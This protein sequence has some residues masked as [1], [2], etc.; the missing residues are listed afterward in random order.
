MTIEFNG[1]GGLMEG[2]FGTAD[3]DVNMDAVLDWDG[4]DDSI[5]MAADIMPAANAAFSVSL[6]FKANSLEASGTNTL[7]TNEVYT[8][9]GFRFG[10]TNENL[11]FWSSQS[12]GGVEITGATDLV[13]GSWYHAVMSYDGSGGT[14]Y[15]NGAVEGTDASG[16]V[17]TSTA[18]IEI[19]G[20]IGGTQAWNGSIADV[21]IYSTALGATEAGILASKIGVDNEIVQSS[22]TRVGHWMLT[23]KNSGSLLNE[24]D[25][26]GTEAALYIDDGADFEVGQYVLIGDQVD[27]IDVVDTS[28][29]YINLDTPRG[30]AG[31]STAAHADNTPVYIIGLEDLSSNNNTLEFQGDLTTPSGDFKFSSWV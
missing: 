9:N 6:W 13:T 31:T 8:T 22:D 4:T 27:F 5:H 25:D 14:L 1:T 21:R 2:D 11:N 24:L 23:V 7:I 10:V 3:I 15:L 28:A 26:D 18:T 29:A 20:P 30:K 19:G 16:L 17:L 12:G